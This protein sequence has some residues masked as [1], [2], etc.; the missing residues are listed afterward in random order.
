MKCYDLPNLSHV[1]I[2]VAREAMFVLRIRGIG[3]VNNNNK[4]YPQVRVSLFS[5]RTKWGNLENA[6]AISPVHW[7]FPILLPEALH[8][9]TSLS[10]WNSV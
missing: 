3:T 10:P 5:Q 1:L 9:D 4:W 6:V 2:P 7:V 8:N